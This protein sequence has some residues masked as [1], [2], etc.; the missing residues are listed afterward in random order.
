M[1]TCLLITVMF[2][3]VIHAI[4]SA[5]S[6]GY[7]TSTLTTVNEYT[8]S[9]TIWSEVATVT[10]TE[11]GVQTLVYTSFAVSG[12]D[13]YHCE[14]YSLQFY[15]HQNAPVSGV[16]T[17]SQSDSI[18]AYILTGEQHSEILTAPCDDI[19]NYASRIWGSPGD[20]GTTFTVNWTPKVDG[21]YWLTVLSWAPSTN[22]VKITLQSSY[23]HAVISLQYSTTIVISEFA[24]TRII[25][26]VQTQPQTQQ[27][28]SAGSAIMLPTLIAIVI[29]V[30]AI[31][32]VM[33]KRKKKQYSV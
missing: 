5:M 13:I 26:S 33:L 12:V 30:L 8:Q 21:N 28:P 23:I 24:T 17:A 14:L 31:P 25:T 22:P 29:L 32:T 20:H 6:Q 3:S 11:S 7:L 9:S 10:S 4:P 2:G 19:Q 18:G 27:T 15:A 16:I 1:L